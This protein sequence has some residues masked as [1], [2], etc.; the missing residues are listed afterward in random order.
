MSDQPT[1]IDDVRRAKEL[2]D[3]ESNSMEAHVAMLRKIQAEFLS[4]QGLFAS[5]PCNN[6]EVHS[7]AEGPKDSAS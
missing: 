3:S 2:L 6:A 7:S 5:L 4:R 1:M